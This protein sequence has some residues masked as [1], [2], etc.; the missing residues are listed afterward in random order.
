[1]QPRA[2]KAIP[3]AQASSI[4]TAAEREHDA[5]QRSKLGALQIDLDAEGLDQLAQRNEVLMVLSGSF[6]VLEASRTCRIV[7]GKGDVIHADKTPLQSVRIRRIAELR[8][9]WTTGREA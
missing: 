5:A 8:L 9:P 4:R 2:G 3:K 1:V 7:G 6:G